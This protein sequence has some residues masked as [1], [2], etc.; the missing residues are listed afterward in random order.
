M[1]PVT[2]AF[3]SVAWLVLELVLNVKLGGFFNTWAWIYVFV[4]GA[5]TLFYEGVCALTV[6]IAASYAR[7]VNVPLRDVEEF[8]FLSTPLPKLREAMF[9]WNKRRFQEELAILRA[10]AG[11]AKVLKKHS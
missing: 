8:F 10:T 7:Q 1:L 3:A 5:L 4:L 6:L 9:S 2:A 11:L